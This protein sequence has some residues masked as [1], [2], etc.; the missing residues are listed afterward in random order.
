MMSRHYVKLLLFCIPLVL[1]TGA[2]TFATDKMDDSATGSLVGQF[3]I[4]RKTTLAN[5][6]LFI[7]NQAMGT[8]SADKYVRVPDQ[9]AELDNE[10][11]F[12]LELPAGTYFIS[13]VKAPEGG[14]MG[15]P[16]AGELI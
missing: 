5:G 13:A 11:K 8:P 7:Y 4:N 14:A 10:G 16:A 6:R 1:F 15:P 9:L 2:I 3:K 12:V